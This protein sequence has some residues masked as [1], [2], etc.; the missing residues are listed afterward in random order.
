MTMSNYQIGKFYKSKT[1]QECGHNFF[2]GE[3]KLK[4]IF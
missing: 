3:Y 1:H 4:I 2:E